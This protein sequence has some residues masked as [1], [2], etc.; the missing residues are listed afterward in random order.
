MASELSH[1][2]RVTRLYRRSLKHL[3][4]WAIDR[5]VWRH[6]AVNLR[7]RFDANK[8]V[9]DMKRATALLEA[10]ERDFEKHKHPSPYICKIS[11]VERVTEPFPKK[12]PLSMS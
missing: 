10:G 11:R 5:S 2:Q 9:K 7:A 4:S 12:G 6:E 1:A 3:L 8:H